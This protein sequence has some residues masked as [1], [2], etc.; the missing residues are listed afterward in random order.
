MTKPFSQACENNKQPILDVL[1]DAF[2]DRQRVLEIG[3][4]TGQHAAFFAEHLPHVQWQP[5][6]V[7]EHLA[8]IEQWRSA[9][10]LTNLPSAIEFDVNNQTWPCVNIGIDA[11][12]SANT[13]H[14]MSWREVETTF[15]LLA[16]NISM[17][18]KLCIYGPFNYEGQYTSDSN[19]RFD[20]WLHARDPQSGI[21]DFEKV[22]GLAEAA[23]FRLLDDFALPSNNRLLYWRKFG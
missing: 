12:F 11:V 14:I 22:D 13:L 6:D 18:C 4:G 10:G 2:A 21:R 7:P 23:G 5:S 16:D 19:A 15:Q 17:D 9:A 3:S 8:G 1:S 20:D